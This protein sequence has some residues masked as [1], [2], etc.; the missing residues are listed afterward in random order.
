MH[1]HTHACRVGVS[2]DLLT[3]ATVMG[4]HSPAWGNVELITARIWS[5]T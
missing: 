1:T 3:T 5:V 2:Q 4:W